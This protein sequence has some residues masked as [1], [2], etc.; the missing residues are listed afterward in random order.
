[1]NFNN[2]H[3]IIGLVQWN[4]KLAVIIYQQLIN[5]NITLLSIN[6]Y[7]FSVIFNPFKK[8]TNPIH[9]IHTKT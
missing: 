6:G 1:M 5:H 2:L 4:M 9:A 8:H 7:F 3:E